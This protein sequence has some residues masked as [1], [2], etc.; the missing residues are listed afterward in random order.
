MPRGAERLRGG[1]GGRDLRA[2]SGYDARTEI[3]TA[4]NEHGLQSIEINRAHTF[5]NGRSNHDH[6]P[7]ISGVTMIP[8][9]PRD[10]HYMQLPR[11]VLI[12][13]GVAP[14][15][16]ETLTRLG[17]KGPALVVT[18]HTVVSIA[19]ETI[20][21]SLKRAGLKSS[22]IIVESATTEEVSRVEDEIRQIKP[23]IV[24]G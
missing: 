16:G 21:D 20:V 9:I 23:D 7:P 8:A 10:S 5:S 24:V 14:L 22:T 13:K 17:F 3:T 6:F 19:G 18:G 15:V 12:G 1:G 4:C 11:E 2:D